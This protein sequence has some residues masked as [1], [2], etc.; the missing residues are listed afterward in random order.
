[1][2]G[3]AI[4]LHPYTL[5]A[6]SLILHEPATNAVKSGPLSQLGGRVSLRSSLDEKGCL[7]MGWIEGG[8]PAVPRLEHALISP[9]CRLI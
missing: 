6:F 8:G 1:M 7:R 2:P 5:Q 3:A 9:R 4:E